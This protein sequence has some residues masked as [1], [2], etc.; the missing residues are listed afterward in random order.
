MT[1]DRLSRISNAHE[2]FTVRELESLSGCFQYMRG[3]LE[4]AL[5]LI[6]VTLHKLPCRPLP[7]SAIFAVKAFE[8]R[9][10]RVAMKCSTS[11]VIFI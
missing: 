4:S 11:D 5:V 8:W 1:L 10:L 7:P 2:R 9:A 6:L 3:Q